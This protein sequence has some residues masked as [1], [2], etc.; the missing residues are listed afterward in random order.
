LALSLEENVPGFF[1]NILFRS[2][3]KMQSLHKKAYD[4]YLRLYSTP[5]EVKGY[6]QPLVSY[7]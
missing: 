4:M 3:L 7:T 2:S 6:D 1:R 5:D